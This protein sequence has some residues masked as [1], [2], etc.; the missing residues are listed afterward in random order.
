LH[1]HA[2]RAGDGPRSAS[3]P[4]REPSSARSSYN[5]TKARATTYTILLALA[6]AAGRG[7]PALRFAACAGK[8]GP[9]QE[10]KKGVETYG[11]WFNPALRLTDGAL[12]IP[13]GP[14][15]GIADPKK[16]LAGSTPME[17]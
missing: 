7:R 2:L 11:R 8:L 12:T 15:V 14:G 9:W 10:Y 1:S 17:L 16:I 6:R 13:Q 4:D 3:C 5:N